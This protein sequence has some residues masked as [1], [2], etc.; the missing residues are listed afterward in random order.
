MN[1]PSFDAAA[2]IPMTRF[3]ERPEGRIGYDVDGDGPLLVLVPGLGDL[4]GGYRFL[5]PGLREAGYRVATCDLR[6]HGDSDPTFASYGVAETAEDTLALI[7]E[8]D[9][10]AVIV[11]NSM[12]AG[13]GV[14]AAAAEPELVDGLV[15]LAP[16]LRDA[17]RNWL[18]R[19]EFRMAI[20]RPWTASAWKAYI[21]KLYAGQKPPDFVSYR[22]QVISSLRRPGYAEAFS[23]TAHLSHDSAT[24]RLY[25][26]SS[27]ALVI[28]GEL[29]P[30]FEDPAGETDWVAEML[31]AEAVIVPDAGHY[32]QSQQP[33]RTTATI[34]GFLRTLGL[35]A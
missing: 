26:V 5:A 9:D 19:M 4:R 11:G 3:L 27:P 16:F 34:L 8:L 24:A 15:L 18:Q 35:D 6:G 28:M 1:V 29:D 2:D 33:E 13:A 22:D 17:K 32:P 12:G 14:I 21:P 23:M 10:S 7:H 20:D 31:E 30:G 25:E